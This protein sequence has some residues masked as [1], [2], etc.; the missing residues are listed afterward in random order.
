M[1]CHITSTQ[2]SALT[3]LSLSF[4]YVTQFRKIMPVVSLHLLS[5]V[6]IIVG[7]VAHRTVLEP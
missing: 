1:T 4:P 7:P 2:E 5:P 6:L 3:L